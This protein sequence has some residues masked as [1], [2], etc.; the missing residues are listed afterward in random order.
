[1]H[2]L[3]NG[4]SFS[5]RFTTNFWGTTFF[6]CHFYWGSHNTNFNIFNATIYSDVGV[7]IISGVPNN[8]TP[9]WA[10]CQSKDDDLGMQR[11]NNGQS[12]SWKFTT[13]VWGSTL[14]L[15]HFY[16]GSHNTTIFDACLQCQNR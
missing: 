13:N 2:M 16:W 3:N 9:L 15:C 5:W 1:M 8:P 7:H 10:R 4:Q 6:F 12:F 11:I 14:F